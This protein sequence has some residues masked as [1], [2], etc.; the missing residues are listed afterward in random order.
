MPDPG[1]R[2]PTGTVRGIAY[3]RTDS[4]PMSV[5]E[6]CTVLAGRGLD[7]EN[8]PPGKREVTLLSLESWVE[9]CRDLGAELPWHARRA[10]F[11]VEGIDLAVLIGRT[12][13]IGGARVRLHGETR[14]C[15]IMDDAR[16]GLRTALVPDFRGGVYGQVLT[17]GVVRVGDRVA[18]EADPIA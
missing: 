8:R 1:D 9:T 15:R 16:D 4:E 5:I 2:H 10:N 6:E 3:R 14:P 7:V 11:L 18:R 13:T 12:I 17:G